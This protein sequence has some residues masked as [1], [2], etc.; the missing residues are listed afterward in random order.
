MSKNK[1][2]YLQ[3]ILQHAAGTNRHPQ[4]FKSPHDSLNNVRR[5]FEDIRP[6]IVEQMVERILTSKAIDTQRHMLHHRTGRLSVNQ[7]SVKAKMD[8]SKLQI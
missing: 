3:A 1:T 4:A 6:N 8:Y 2:T 7:I 5:R